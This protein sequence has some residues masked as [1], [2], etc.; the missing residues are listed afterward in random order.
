MH[1]FHD[2]TKAAGYGVFYWLCCRVTKSNGK[3]KGEQISYPVLVLIVFKLI[4]LSD[5]P[6]LAWPSSYP[7]VEY[8]GILR[9]ETLLI[10]INNA[11]NVF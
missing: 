4:N 11:P 1:I 3:Q 7:N 10:Q 2:E 8:D 6:Q 9:H 5:W